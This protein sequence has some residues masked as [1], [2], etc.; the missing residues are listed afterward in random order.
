MRVKKENA[1]RIK[2][3]LLAGERLSITTDEYT[4]IQNKRYTAVNLHP[5]TGR[6]IKIGMMRI[7]GSLPGKKAASD[8]NAKL[9]KYGVNADKHV[10]ANTTDGAKG[11]RK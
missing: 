4:S 9:R 11:K 3:K 8:L 7:W 6:P 10:V 1:A 2:K 5:P